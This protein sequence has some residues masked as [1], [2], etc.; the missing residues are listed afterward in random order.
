[1]HNLLFTLPFCQPHHASQ[2]AATPAPAEAAATEAPRAP[3]TYRQQLRQ[4]RRIIGENIRHARTQK[5][6]T[7][8]QLSRTTGIPEHLLDQYELGKN[9]ISIEEIIK[10]TAYISASTSIP[11]PRSHH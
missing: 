7:L 11:H 10:I 2:H 5:R 8:R 6:M 4:L 3:L 1:M 9:E